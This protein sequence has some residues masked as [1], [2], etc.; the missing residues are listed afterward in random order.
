MVRKHSASIGKPTVDKQEAPDVEMDSGFWHDV[1]N[2]YFI[3]GKELRGGQHDDDL[4]FLVR[5][6]VIPYVLTVNLLHFFL[7][8]L[9]SVHL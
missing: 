2:L 3:H 9:H 6:A 8:F 4:I 1:F 7:F 5:K